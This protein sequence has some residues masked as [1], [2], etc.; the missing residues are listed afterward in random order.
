MI[1]AQ[2]ISGFLLPII[3]IFMLKLINNVNIMGKYK[4]NML[5]NIIAW[6]VC[7]VLIVMTVLFII[8]SIKNYF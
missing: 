5:Y 2:A 8:L 7:I 6:I 1:N 4:N 3:L